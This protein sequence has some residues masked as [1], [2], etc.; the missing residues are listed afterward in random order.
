M[1]SEFRAYDS[2]QDKAQDRCN[3][4]KQSQKASL[5]AS[6]PVDSLWYVAH[7]LN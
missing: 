6:R 2:F 7:N 3:P 5:D 1:V 4:S